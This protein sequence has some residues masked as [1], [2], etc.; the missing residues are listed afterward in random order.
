M[1]LREWKKREEKKRGKEKKS[2]A[3]RC[4]IFFILNWVWMLVD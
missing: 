1:E 4:K 3:K 2:K